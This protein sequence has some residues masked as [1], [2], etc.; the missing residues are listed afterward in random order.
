MKKV[1]GGEVEGEIF[2]KKEMIK[3]GKEDLKK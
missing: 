3:K 1:R 2:R